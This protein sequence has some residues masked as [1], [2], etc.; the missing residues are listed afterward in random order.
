[1]ARTESNEFEVGK[2]APD[3][4][5]Q[6]TIDDTWVDLQSFKGI[7]GTVIVFICNHCPFVIHINEKLVDLANEYQP[8]GIA[9]IAISSNDIE[10]YPQDAPHLMK[11][12]GQDLQYPFPYLFDETQEV[13]KMYAAACTPDFYLFDTDLKAV[14]HGQ[15]DDSR[16]GNGKPVTGNDLKNAMENLLQNKPSLQIQ[17]PSVGCGIKWK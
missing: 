4:T 7:Q 8:K 11:K 17:K 2:K 1:M 10:K 14:Y 13:A 5:L 15:L 3:F 12:V 6:N 16:P 9:F